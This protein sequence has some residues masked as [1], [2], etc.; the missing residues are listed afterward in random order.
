[1]Q[2]MVN[3]A[4]RAARQAGEMIVKAAD[5]LES[6]EVSEKS[7]NDFVTEIDKRSEQIIIDSILKAY[8]DHHFLSEERGFDGNNSSDIQ[9][10][11]DPLDG[12]TNFVRGIP[13][14]SVSI[15]C[16][17]KG[18]LEHAVVLEPFSHDE[19]T[20][21]RGFGAKL[22]GRRIRVSGK[23]DKNGALYATGVPFNDPS[24]KHM[25]EYL[26]CLH[27]FAENSCGVRR[28]GVASLDL[29]YVASGKFDVFFEMYLKPWDIAAGALLV[30]E[31]GGFVSDFSGGENF[32]SSGHILA[33][34]PKLFKPSLKTISKH[35]SQLKN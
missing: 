14:V 6:V 8:P 18:K 12:T 2:P 1:M 7:K 11:I 26:K 5:N 29:A 23:T 9:W 10:I 16:M 19:F 4:L 34:T 35:L 13:Y 27:E 25:K 24:F 15:A 28:M 3:I 30:R 31:A 20:A 21:S 32:M 17:I 22:N 33:T